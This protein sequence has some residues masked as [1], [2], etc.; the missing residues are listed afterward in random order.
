MVKLTLPT[1]SNERKDIPVMSGCMN[2]FPAALAEVAKISV[3]GNRK[4]NPGST[5]LFH[6]RGKSMDHGDCI[7]RHT[8]DIEDLKA[9]IR[10]ADE[11]IPG[12]IHSPANVDQLIEEA[13]YRAWR[14]LAELQQLCEQHRGMPLAPAARQ[15][16]MLEAIATAQMATPHPLSVQ[17]RFAPDPVKATSF[18]RGD[19]VVLQTEKEAKRIEQM[20]ARVGETS[21]LSFGLD[22]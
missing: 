12:A 18:R 10:R 9:R 5:E 6:A 7:V 14:S 21:A 4:H 11:A 15:P 19:S 20:R 3:A 16:T 2:Y 8:M 1:D 22:Q 13:A 17:E